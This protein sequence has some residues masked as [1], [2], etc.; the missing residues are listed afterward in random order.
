MKKIR[1]PYHYDV[2]LVVAL[3][4]LPMAWLIFA[5]VGGQLGVNP[6]ETLIRDLGEWGLR[7]LIATLMISPIASLRALADL[8]AIETPSGPD[9]SLLYRRASYGLSLV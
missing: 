1:P 5:L 2:V 7:F 6:I 9:V 4:A 3:A 8:I